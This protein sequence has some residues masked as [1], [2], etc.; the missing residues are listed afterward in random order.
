[1]YE[2]D[3]FLQ[4]LTPLK[5]TREHDGTTPF[6]FPPESAVRESDALLSTLEKQPFVAIFPGAST[7]VRLWGS[8]RFQ[9][10]V[11]R[12]DANGLRSVVI[13]GVEDRIQGE[14]IIAGSSGALNLAG[15]TSLA[16]TAAIIASSRLL[17]SGDSGVLHIGVG[18]GVPT[19]SLF[20]P[21][22]SSKW[23]P[24]GNRHI[25]L[26]KGLPCS[27]C[28]RFGTTPPCPHGIRCLSEITPT[29]VGSAVLKIIKKTRPNILK[30]NA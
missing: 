19:V 21:G 11:E 29:E 10:V 1:M 8:E 7:K 3:S 2:A 4:L 12:L 5:I 23:A 26:N 17:L 15:K 20:G 30:Q 22:I 24:C 16:V 6:L 13:G 18:V 27:P 25:V 28:T 14:E 9:Q